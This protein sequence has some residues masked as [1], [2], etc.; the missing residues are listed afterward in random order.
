MEIRRIQLSCRTLVSNLPSEI[1]SLPSFT[2]LGFKPG[3]LTLHSKDISSFSFA[4][5]SE[6]GFMMSNGISV[7]QKVE[8]NLSG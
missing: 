7:G 3:L 2:H 5:I 8:A 4:C 6:S 1:I